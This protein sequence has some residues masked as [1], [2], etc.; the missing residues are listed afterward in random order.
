MVTGFEE[1]KAARRETWAAKGARRVVTL[2]RVTEGLVCADGGLWND[3]RRTMSCAW[4]ADLSMEP[5]TFREFSAQAQQPRNA[6]FL[7]KNTI[8]RYGGCSWGAARA[9][10][11]QSQCAAMLEALGKLLGWHWLQPGL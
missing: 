3:E 4:R 5:R 9:Y 6:P 1:Q 2:A 7:F 11:G 10:K 8:N